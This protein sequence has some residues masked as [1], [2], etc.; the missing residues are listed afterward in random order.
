MYWENTRFGLCPRCAGRMNMLPEKNLAV[1][2]ADGKD[3]ECRFYMQM[4]RYEDIAENGPAPRGASE[5]VR[6]QWQLL[7]EK[8]CPRCASGWEKDEY[9]EH[10]RCPQEYCSFR[11]SFAKVYEMITDPGHMCNS[12][13]GKPY[14]DDVIKNIAIMKRN[15][16]GDDNVT[17]QE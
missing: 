8:R 14:Q 12:H 17:D 1:C 13:K 2:R 15:Y 9:T 5:I 3:D 16:Y 10:V 6:P 11:A 7:H 4:S